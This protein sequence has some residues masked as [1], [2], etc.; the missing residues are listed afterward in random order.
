MEL[1]VLGFNR[2]V[3][4][5]VDIGYPNHIKEFEYDPTFPIR[6]V[7]FEIYIMYYPQY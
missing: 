3:D 7:L 2:T 4:R 5:L 1:E 6:L